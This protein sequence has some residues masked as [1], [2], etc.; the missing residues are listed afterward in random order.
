[1]CCRLLLLGRALTVCAVLAASA[2]FGQS[3][4]VV[5]ESETNY[6]VEASARA[7]TP[8]T[9]QASANLH[10]W[11][12]LHENVQEPYSY[13]FDGSAAA[14]RYFRLTPP[15]P[16]APPIRILMLGDSMTSDCCGWGGGMY[17][18]F[19]PNATVINYAQAWTSSKVFLHSAEL[20]KMLLVK[21]DYVLIQY[22]YMD[23]AWGADLAPES[24]T[25]PE[26]F[27]DNL[28]TLINMVRGFNG[29]PILVTVHSARDWDAEGRVIPS[30]TDRNAVTK[31][32]AAEVQTPLI[33][34]NQLSLD[35]F[36]KLGPSCAE[37]FHLLGFAPNDVMHMSPLG[38]QYIAQLV[39]NALP[40][41]FGP[42]L[43][44]IFDP[45]PKP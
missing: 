43:T 30:W 38:A 39:V 36:N 7:G 27:A 2:A 4:S 17:R 35:L 21:P 26:E 42:Y 44:G 6:W 22:G 29:V 11:T 34:L 12:D 31:K 13:S 1:M 5:K 41:S 3:L 16:E 10:L 24:Y 19:K 15:A 37:P 45:P 25:S 14:Q 18:Y 32:V 28:K 40:D 23:Q 20:D 8:Q 33:D 9:L